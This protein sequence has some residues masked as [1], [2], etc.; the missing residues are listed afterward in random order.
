MKNKFTTY[1]M[2]ATALLAALMC[3]LGPLSL[4]IGPVPISLTNLVVCLAVCLLGA[5]LSTVSVLVYLVLGA[6]GL[7]VFSGYAGGLAKLAGPTGGYLIGFLP[8]A[9]IAGLV[10]E[11]CGGKK[12]P[13]YLGMV[14]GCA[15]DYLF[16]T[17]WFVVVM[18]CDVWYAL[19]ACVLPF[20]VG[21]LLKMAL[22]LVVGMLVRE[23]LVK[24]GLAKG[25]A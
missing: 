21:D 19:T 15:V 11:R 14:A 4:P 18:Q 20:I 8:M 24:A 10:M 17:V 16:G 22:A 13:T 23:R 7:P 6:V 1:Q 9:L 5:R 25:L 3:V 2:A 12:L